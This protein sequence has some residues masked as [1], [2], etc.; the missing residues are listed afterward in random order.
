MNRKTFLKYSLSAGVGACALGSMYGCSLLDEKEMRVGLIADL[1]KEGYLVG[2][3]NRKKIFTTRLEGKLVIFSLVC[4]HKR[5]TV[6]FEED[7]E[8]FV[9]PCHEGTYD[10]YGQVID[11]PPPE[12][13]RRYRN[14]IRGEEIW[15]INEYLKT[16]FSTS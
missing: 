15:V 2:R 12:P 3:F 7:T 16:D 10:K 13:L 14:E 9:C 6:A 5:C 4:R 8:Q 11:G 1:E